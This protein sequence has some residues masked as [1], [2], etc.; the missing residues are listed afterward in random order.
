MP[1][2]EEPMM[3]AWL[4]DAWQSRVLPMLAASLVAQQ[5]N[6]RAVIDAQLAAGGQ[7]EYCIDTERQR[8]VFGVGG[9]AFAEASFEAIVGVP[10]G[11]PTH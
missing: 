9:L 4:A 2:P 10:L 8:V 5:P 3:P 11:G 6:E 7:I 1:Q